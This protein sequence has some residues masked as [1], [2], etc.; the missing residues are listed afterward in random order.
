MLYGYKLWPTCDD[1]YSS[2]EAKIKGTRLRSF[3]DNRICVCLD[4]SLKPV[5][6]VRS[7]MYRDPESPTLFGDKEIHHYKLEAE[8]SPILVCDGVL[9]PQ[10]FEGYET[11]EDGLI[12]SWNWQYSDGVLLYGLAEGYPW[13]GYHYVS[14]K[15]FNFNTGRFHQSG[16]WTDNVIDFKEE[17]HAWW[18]IDVYD[19]NG[20][21]I[22]PWDDYWKRVR[23]VEFE[24]QK[25]QLPAG[26][27]RDI[28]RVYF[29]NHSDYQEAKVKMFSD[30]LSKLNV[31]DNNIAN[32]KDLVEFVSDARS[33]RLTELYQ[34]FVDIAKGNGSLKKIGRA[35]GKAWLAYRYQYNTAKQDAEQFVDAAL[36]DYWEK[37]SAQTIA[38]PLRSSFYDPDNYCVYHLKLRVEDDMHDAFLSM[39]NQ[40]RRFGLLPSF[41]TVWDM[42]PFSFAVDWVA[43]VDKNLSAFDELYY[44]QSYNILEALVSMKRQKVIDLAGMS[45]TFTEYDRHFES[46]FPE[47]TWVSDDSSGTVTRTLKRVADVG[48]LLV[49]AF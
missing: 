22:F 41:H 32:I 45:V 34:D 47:W 4:E 13:Y 33:G 36:N 39:S 21:L 12:A 49:Q 11:Y 48:S 46:S 24:V 9:C 31:S 14:V 38:H 6:L 37:I 42:I 7:Q 30:A 5:K 26:D 1:Y 3:Q 18:R 17:S 2:E 25:P 19:P 28:F 10:S 20:Q 40:V 35:S 29:P 16:Y 43:P 23:P 44:A 15:K 8:A 27:L